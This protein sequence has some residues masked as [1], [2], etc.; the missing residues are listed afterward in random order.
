MHIAA[1]VAFLALPAEARRLAQ[2]PSEP[3]HPPS[4]TWV[5][6]EPVSQRVIDG[7]LEDPMFELFSELTDVDAAR[8]VRTH[9][10]EIKACYRLEAHRANLAGGKAMLS[11]EIDSDGAVTQS[12]L[13]APTLAGSSVPSCVSSAA[14]RWTF[15]RSFSRKHFSYPIVFIDG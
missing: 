13:E 11:L 15:P 4:L 6:D 7:I 12:S 10:I 5:D 9:L 1:L 8:I 2:K 3:P 14:Q